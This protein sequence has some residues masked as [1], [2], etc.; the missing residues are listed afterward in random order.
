MS[1]AAGVPFPFV[2]D[3]PNYSPAGSASIIVFKGINDPIWYKYKCYSTAA[4]VP[5]ALGPRGLT[6]TVSSLISDRSTLP[7]PSRLVKI[8]ETQELE[9]IRHRTGFVVTG[10]FRICG[11]EISEAPEPS[12]CADQKSN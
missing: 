5:E 10:V 12:F 1:I 8:Q 3:N 11:P 7:Q 4:H 2:L 6:V 9:T